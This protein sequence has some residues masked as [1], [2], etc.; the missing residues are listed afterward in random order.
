MKPLALSRP[1]RG[2]SLIEVLVTMVILAFGLIGIAAFQSKA[3]VGTIESFQRAQAVVLLQDMQ[4]RIEGH[5]ANAGDYVSSTVYGTGDGLPDD[6][7]AYADGSAARDLCEWSRAL[8][9]A[10]EVKNSAKLGTMANPRGCIEELQAP[11][12]SDGVCRQGIYR[13]T[14]AW[15]GQHETVAPALSCGQG[16][17][18]ADT[19]R[20]AIATRVAIGLPSCH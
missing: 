16:L 17:Y 5:S 12:P 19:Y 4:Q 1:V 14:I 11:D 10:A 18:G 8:K 3:Q 13:I 6:C 7:S 2:T 20:R 15:Q 9:G